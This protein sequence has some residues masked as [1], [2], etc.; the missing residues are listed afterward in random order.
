ENSPYYADLAAKAVNG[1][2]G[3]WGSLSGCSTSCG[4]G[5]RRRTRQ[6]NNPPPSGAGVSCKTGSSIEYRACTNRPCPMLMENGVIGQHLV[7][8]LQHAGEVPKHGTD[9]VTVQ[10]QIMVVMTAWVLTE[11]L[12]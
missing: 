5:S 11:K 3:S 2:W 1:A 6:C 9:H 7:P 12:S 10:Y 4:R 8:V